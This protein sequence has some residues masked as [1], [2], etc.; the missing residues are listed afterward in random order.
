M[1]FSFNPQ[2]GLVY[3]D[4]EVEGPTGTGSLLLTLDTGAGRSV[5]SLPKLLRIGYDPSQAVTQT[6]ATTASGMVSAPII[7]VLRLKALGQERTDLDI[8]GH[9]L[10]P[11]ASS[12]GLLGLDFL[13]GLTLT[14]DFCNGEIELV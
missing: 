4:A 11:T 5:I 14:L 7:R 12:D 9:S 2:Y 10:P 6:T 1:K 3:V 8:I 13:R